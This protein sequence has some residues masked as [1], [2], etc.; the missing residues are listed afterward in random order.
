MGNFAENFAST[1]YELPTGSFAETIDWN[2]GTFADQW[3]AP[4]V[5]PSGV[6]GS[7]GDVEL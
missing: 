6:K 4:V 1:D 7:F 3:R 2:I 5:L